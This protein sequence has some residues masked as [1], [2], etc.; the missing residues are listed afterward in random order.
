MQYGSGS[1]RIRDKS[2]ISVVGGAQIQKTKLISPAAVQT[3]AVPIAYPAAYEMP[4][5]GCGSKQAAVDE[6]SSTT[7]TAGTWDGDETFPPEGVLGLEGGTYC[8]RGDVEIKG[9]TTLEGKGVTIILEDGNFIVRGGAQ[10]TLTAP[11]SGPAKGLLIYMPIQN[12]RRIALNGGFDS[13]YR[14]TILAPAG[15]VILNG[16]DSKYGYHSQII[17]Y[18]IDVPGQDVIVINYSANENYYTY[19]MPEVLL[20]Q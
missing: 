12:A 11:Q 15:D 16:M 14:G 13:R 5:I 9:G 2:P 20:S 10:V 3:G 1:I 8:I 19:K 7:M 18:T 6:F 17:G 4:K